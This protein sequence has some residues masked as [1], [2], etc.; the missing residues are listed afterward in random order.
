MP[1]K[2]FQ[3]LEVY[4]LAHSFAMKIFYITQTFPKEEKY[5]LTDQMIRS[6]RSIA[7][8]IA[9]GWGKRI[10][11]NHFK[12]HL[13]DANGSLEESKSWLL[14]SKDCNYINQYEL[15]ELFKQSET[16]GAKLWRLYDN[17]K[18]F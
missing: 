15:S 2:T 16:I 5:S 1:I 12:K 3:D 9:E 14:F 6:T 7:A 17:W 10:Y 4:Q 8:N 18:S 13:I 11:I